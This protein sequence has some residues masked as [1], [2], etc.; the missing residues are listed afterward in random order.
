M[1][2]QSMHSGAFFF[3]FKIEAVFY[4]WRARRRGYRATIKRS[5][6]WYMHG[7]RWVVYLSEG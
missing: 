7:G 6:N 5:S 3:F 4:A 2:G 1:S